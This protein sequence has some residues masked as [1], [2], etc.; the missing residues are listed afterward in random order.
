[1]AKEGTKGNHTLPKKQAKKSKHSS[2]D[3]MRR[4]YRSRQDKVIAGVCGGIGEYF[5]VDP[6]W[7]RIAFVLLIFAQGVGVI[8]YIIAFLLMPENP[9]Q[10]KEK[11]TQFE[12]TI[13]DMTRNR[14]GKGSYI[15]GAILIVIGAIFLLQN[16]FSWFSFAYVWP[17]ILIALGVFLLQHKR[18]K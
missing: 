9:H 11:T 3:D 12:T 15:M 13:S 16:L 18:S 7:I 2:K 6:V 14:Q 17:L 10:K 4:L 1:M 8:L 5:K